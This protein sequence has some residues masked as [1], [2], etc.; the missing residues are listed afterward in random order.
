MTPEIREP[1]E[2]ERDQVAHVLRTS[3]NFPK[4]WLETR[5][6]T[7]PLD[8]LRC[9]YDASGRVVATA[10]EHRFRQWFGG[11]DLGSAGIFGVATLPEHRVSGLASAALLQI[12]REARARGTSLSALYPV[13]LRPYRKLGYELAGTYSEHRLNLDAIPDDLGEDL[14]RIEVLDPSTDL[15]AMKAIYRSWASG[16]NGPVE[17]TDDGWW[18]R[19]I[20]EPWGDE[21]SRAVVV[22]DDAGAV[23]GFAAYRCR[24]VEGHLDVSFGIECDVFATI[25]GRATRALLSYFRRFRG[26]GTWLEWNGPAEDPMA[27]LLP[28][29]RISTPF[30]HRWMLRLLDVPAAL[31]GRGYPPVD[32]DAELAVEDAQFPENAGPWRL[33]AREGVVQVERAEGSVRT[34]PIP[35]GA[36]SAIFSGYLRVRD[37]IQLGHLDGADPAG[38]ALERLF[39]G[40]GPWSPFFF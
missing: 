35:I 14:P 24:N 28:E 39:S 8:D 7:I 18:T 31:S 3:L 25:T 34:R 36:L 23:E 33:T 40:P 20:L 30:R 9:A 2:D 16:H 22:R 6:P 37:A 4:A 5:A 21:I 12:L 32:A 27:M 29:Q 13:V 26:V 10:G 15:D 38:P 1:T 11:H 19:R 17:P